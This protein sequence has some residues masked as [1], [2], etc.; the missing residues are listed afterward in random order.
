MNYKEMVMAAYKSGKA[1]EKQMWES[2]DSVSDL[3]CMIKDAH[4]DTYWKFI[5]EQAGIMYG[6]HYNEEFAKHDVAMMQ[7]LG[8]HWSMKQIEEI[9]KGMSFPNETTLCDR[10]VA[11]N[12]WANDLNGV[13]T[14][15]QILKSAYAF[16]F[17]DKDYKGNDKIWCY[18]K[19]VH[20]K[21]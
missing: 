3:L 14:E 21:K 13:L 11:F 6:G 2:I 4:P 20:S 10:Y 15:D 8:E 5:R 19:M 16:W 17:C 7:P 9:T 1:S 18:M 12:A